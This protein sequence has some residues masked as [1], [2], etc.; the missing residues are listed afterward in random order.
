MKSKDFALLLV[1]AIEELM[2]ENYVLRHAIIGHGL[3]AIQQLVDQAK[4]PGSGTRAEVS[5]KLAQIRERIQ[6]ESE[7][8][9]SLADILRSLP[10]KG[11]N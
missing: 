2:I 6:R 7:D 11:T 5:Q 3:T 4:A 10:T 9:Q 8:S 1:D